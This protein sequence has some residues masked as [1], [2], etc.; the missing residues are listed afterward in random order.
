MNEQVEVEVR[1]SSAT[2]DSANFRC[3]ASMSIL[4][5]AKRAGLELSSGCMQG[6]CYTCRSRLI[7]GTVRN[8]RALS[9]YATIDPAALGD[10]RVLLCSVSPTSDVVIVPE[11]PWE[12]ATSLSEEASINE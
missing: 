7:E 10:G 9:R 11:G 2:Q 12:Y 4:R 1:L 6:R 5:A 3:A 8:S